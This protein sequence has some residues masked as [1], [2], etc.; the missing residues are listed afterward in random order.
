MNR[1]E[2]TEGRYSVFAFLSAFCSV[3]L[4]DALSATKVD[5]SKALFDEPS[6]DAMK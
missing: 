2:T 4:A 6:K 5:M 3:L 1:K